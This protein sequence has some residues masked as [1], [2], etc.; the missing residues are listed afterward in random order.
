MI[1]DRGRAPNGGRGQRSDGDTAVRVFLSLWII[2]SLYW[3]TDFVREHFLVLTIVDRHSFALDGFED[4]HPDIFVHTDGHAY[5]GAN[6]GISMLGAIP[7]FIFSPVVDRVAARELAARSTEEE[8]EASYNDPRR[9]RQVFYERVRARGLDVRFGLLGLVTEVFAMAPLSALGG[10]VFFLVLAGAGV[11]R[12]AALGATL[13]YALGTPVFLRSAYLNQN[14]AVGVFGFTGFGLLWNPGG[15]CSWSRRTRLAVAGLCGG[16]ALLCDYSGGLMTALLGLYAVVSLRDEEA[17]PEVI[18]GSLWYVAGSVGPILILWY[19]QWAAF[20]FPFYPPQH[21]MPPVEWSDLGYQGVS[22]PQLDL[23]LMLLFDV[24]FGLVVN[25]PVVLLA[26]VAPILARRQPSILQRRETWLALGVG[27]A[28]LVFFSMVNYTRLQYI[29]G[30][31][32]MVPVLPF[33]VLAAV[34]ALLSLP[35]IVTYLL[36][37]VSILINWGLAMGRF[38]EQ[39]SSILETLGRV[40]LGG[41]QLPA[42][43]TLSKMSAQYL[44]EGSQISAGP[45]LLVAAVV[46]WAVWRIESPWS[47]VTAE[48]S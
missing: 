45:V 12:R 6:P 8:Q 25:A 32:Y 33:L 28:Y 47:P 7:Y 42:L 5:H 29:T 43:N 48:E 21:Y 44:P 14:L 20:G 9:A 1:P 34:P 19:Y 24:R 22:R 16:L 35:R 15:W 38:Q 13:I 40:Y 4:L 17:W 18:R 11:G 39:E 41:L 46:L 27:A 31:R 37:F 2:F 26:L 3:A 36:A 10:M 30:I 23:L